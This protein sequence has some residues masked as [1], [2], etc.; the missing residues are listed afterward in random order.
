MKPRLGTVRTSP[1]LPLPIG[2]AGLCGR[3]CRLTLGGVRTLP[4][5]PSPPSPPLGCRRCGASAGFMRQPRRRLTLTAPAAPR[6]GPR[7][8]SASPAWPL[9]KFD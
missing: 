6:L 2:R 8:G 9:F 7:L 4:L 1:S 3:G 5:P